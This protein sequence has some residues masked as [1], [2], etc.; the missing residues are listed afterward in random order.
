MKLVKVRGDFFYNCKS[1]GSDPDNQL[2]YNEAGRP[3]VLLIRLKYKGENRDFVVPMKS[4][5]AANTDKK[6]FFAL[7][8]NKRT[9]PGN[10]HGIYY[11]KLFPIDRK[12]VQP[13]LIE[14]NTYMQ[15]I[16]TI[17]DK[18]DNEREIVN[19]CQN[20]LREYEMGNKNYYTPNIDLIIELALGN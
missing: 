8:P 12:Y 20:Y 1:L 5:I 19:A 17:I 2:L 7:P 14:G 9:R 15:N 3:C 18:P 6:T 13:Y 4:N 11:V 16:Q 10:Y